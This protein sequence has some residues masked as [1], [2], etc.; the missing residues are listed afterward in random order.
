MGSGAGL[1][2]GR[3]RCWPPGAFALLLWFWHSPV[4]YAATFSSAAVYWSMHLTLFVAAVLLWHGLL[5]RS[6]AR[7]LPVAGAGLISTV[8]MGFLGALITFAP[9]A[10]YAPHALTTGAWGLSSL[11]DQ[12]AGGAIMWIPGCAA[13]LAV[14]MAVLWLALARRPWGPAMP[15][16]ARAR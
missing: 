15:A 6:P 10:L 4:A 12:Q 8:Q 1:P 7:V 13:F 2:P 14:S 11:Q 3:C 5:D 9:R 16:G